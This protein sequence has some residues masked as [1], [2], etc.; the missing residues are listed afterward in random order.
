MIEYFLILLALSATIVG[1]RGDTWDGTQEGVKK[2]R[3]SGWAALAIGVIAAVTSAYQTHKK[4]ELDI[5][6]RVLPYE[7]L[8][9]AVAPLEGFIE[10]LYSDVHGG[11]YFKD[12]HLEMALDSDSLK[13]FDGVNLQQPPL[14][15]WSTATRSNNAEYLCESVQEFDK[16]LNHALQISGQ[17]I[18]KEAFILVSSVRN[19]SLVRQFERMNCC[20]LDP[21]NE[22][23]DGTIKIS[24]GTEPL[25]KDDVRDL[26][27]AIVN[28][29]KHLSA[30]LERANKGIELVR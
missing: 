12:F 18:D 3:M 29:K 19:A 11:M 10:L 16:R 9:K 26:V 14:N 20:F 27:G 1:V 24:L 8:E 15:V 13:K 7:S 22:E 17:F 25:K 6:S 5:T 2:I 23:G 30:T 28:L 21:S 4:D